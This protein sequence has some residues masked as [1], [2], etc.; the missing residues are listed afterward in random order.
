MKY[1][2]YAE[3]YF[4]NQKPFIKESTMNAY[5]FIYDNHI[6]P[7]FADYDINNINSRVAQKFINYLSTKESRKGGLL[8]KKSIIDIMVCF[9]MIMHDAMREGMIPEFTFKVK[10]PN[11]IYDPPQELKILK[12]S[13][14]Q[15]LL[16]YCK[17]NINWNTVG[18]M[19]ALCCGLRIGEICG[20]KWGKVDFDGNNIYV[21]DRKSVV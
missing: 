19:L 20:L 5:L 14:Y 3:Q 6:K 8:T 7:Y 16:K 13:D 15:K 21:E 4:E 18:I 9:K 2:D 1:C 17:D 10:Y 11:D 12:D